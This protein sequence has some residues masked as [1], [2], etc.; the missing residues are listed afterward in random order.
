MTTKERIFMSMTMMPKGT[1]QAALG[2]T[3]LKDALKILNYQFI[4]YGHVIQTTSVIAII[5]FAPV[6]SIL[7]NTF[8]P[9]FLRKDQ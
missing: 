2:A 7:I 6:G 5:I 3:V 1:V 8:G 4:E 9:L